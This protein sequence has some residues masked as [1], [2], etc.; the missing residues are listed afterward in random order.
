M[1]AASSNAVAGSASAQSGRRVCAIIVTYQPNTEG[2]CEVVAQALTQTD[3]L[4]IVD[5]G[6][7]PQ[8]VEWLRQQEQGGR[9]TLLAQGKNTGIAAAQNAAIEWASGSGFEFV[10]ILDQ[11]S[12]PSPEMVSVLIEAL[13]VLERAGVQV[14]AVG[15]LPV[16]PRY[17]AGMSFFRVR[18]LS[19]Y[20]VS[21]DAT[22][23]EPVDVAYLISSGTLARCTIFKQVGLMDEGLFIDGVDLDWCFRAGRHGYAVYV[24]PPARLLHML[25]D[26]RRGVRFVFGYW[27]ILQHSPRRLYYMVRNA[28][29]MARRPHVP[30]GWTLLSLKMTLKR[31]VAFGLLLPPRWKNLCMMLAGLWDGL[32]GRTGPLAEPIDL[33]VHTHPPSHRL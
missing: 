11:D 25:G 3:A 20:P 4:V 19:A 23:T 7:S 15:P 10:L 9:L 18:G 22:A 32:I 14:A 2:L 8:V 21:I 12:V 29:L 17:E 6:S 13:E 33:S 5:N 26:R 31:L 16:D 30:I 28:L 1:R 27:T 24:V